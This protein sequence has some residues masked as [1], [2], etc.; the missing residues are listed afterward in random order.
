VV[1]LLLQNG[2]DPTPT[3]GT[4]R[5]A[6]QQKAIVGDFSLSIKLELESTYGMLLLLDRGLASPLILKAASG[7][8]MR[9]VDLY[10]SEI[11]NRNY[12]DI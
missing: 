5:T 1:E 11:R 6:S 7:I 10:S 12:G 2:A 8:W 3:R 9:G 4:Y